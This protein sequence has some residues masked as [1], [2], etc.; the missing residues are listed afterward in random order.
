MPALWRVDEHADEHGPFRIRVIRKTRRETD[1]SRIALGDERDAIVVG[2]S[3]RCPLVPHGLGE[4][5][6]S[7]QR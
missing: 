1:P 6:L 7:G 3:A 2:G 4:R 5:F